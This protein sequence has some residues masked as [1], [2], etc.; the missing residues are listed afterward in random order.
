MLLPLLT[1]RR[2]I[3]LGRIRDKKVIT[4]IHRDYNGFGRFL[5]YREEKMA[6]SFLRGIIFELKEARTFLALC[7]EF[8]LMAIDTYLRV[9]HDFKRERE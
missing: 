8:V 6:S 4:I 9:K 3:I 1:K 7:F 2:E 5:L